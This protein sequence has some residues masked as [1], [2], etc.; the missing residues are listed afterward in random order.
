MREPSDAQQY[1]VQTLRGPPRARLGGTHISGLSDRHQTARSGTSDRSTAETRSP[2]IA[3]QNAPRSTAVPAIMR[4]RSGRARRRAARN[5]ITYSRRF[6]IGRRDYAVCGLGLAMRR[7]PRTDDWTIERALCADRHEKHA[8]SC[9]PSPVG[10]CGITSGS[11]LRR[12]RLFKVMH[13]LQDA[14]LVAFGVGEHGPR[15]VSCL[16][17]VAPRCAE[18]QRPLSRVVATGRA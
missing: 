12:C 13:R 1:A 7:G 9:A 18:S 8:G 14:E 10:R 3:S 16:A 4:S 5:A 15:L 11:T 2:I 17:D 6:G